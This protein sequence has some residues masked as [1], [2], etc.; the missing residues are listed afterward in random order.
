[1]SLNSGSAVRHSFSEHV[2][3]HAR[4]ADIPFL[5]ERERVMSMEFSRRDSLDL[6]SAA[7]CAVSLI[8]LKPPWCPLTEAMMWRETSAAKEENILAALHRDLQFLKMRLR[9]GYG[10]IAGDR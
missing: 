3:F 8:W 9:E 10:G 2:F 4:K 1:V 5:D 6:W 7:A